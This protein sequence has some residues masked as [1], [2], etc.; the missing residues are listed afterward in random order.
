MY[1]FPRVFNLD[2]IFA[3]KLDLDNDFSFPD[4]SKKSSPSM[5][6]LENEVFFQKRDVLLKFQLLI[7]NFSFF[8]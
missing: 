7:F 8:F 1:K 3:L 6:P 5:R 4:K 2:F